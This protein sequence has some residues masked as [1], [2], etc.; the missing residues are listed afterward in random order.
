MSML[1]EMI[2]RHDMALDDA[3]RMLIDRG[4]PVNMF[5]R[6][7]GMDELT[8]QMRQQLEARKQAILDEFD[9]ESARLEA[10]R[11]VKEASQKIQNAA[12]KS[13]EAA[14]IKDMIDRRALDELYRSKMKT[15]VPRAE[16][17]QAVHDLEDLVT[18]ENGQ[19]Q[20]DFRGKTRL[21]KKEALEILELLAELDK[22][23]QALREAEEN[24]DLFNFSL[25]RIARHLGPEQYQ[26]FLE[27]RERILQQMRELME[28]QGQIIQEESGEMRLSPG[29]IRKIGRRALEEIFSSMKSD[30]AGGAHEANEPGDSENTS[31]K[32]RPMEFGDSVSNL[33]LSA[34]IINAF[35][36]RQSTR[37][38]YAEMEVFEPRGQARSSTVMLIDMS[39]SMMRSDRFYNAKKVILALDALI[40]QDYPDEKLLVVGFGTLARLIT[41]AEIPSLQPYP[42][43]M[44]DP[45]IRL[46]FDMARAGMR[47]KVPEYFTNLQRGLEL[48]RSLL[49]SG[50]TRNKQIILITDGVPTAHS[51]NGKLHINYPPSPADF[52]F[53][54]R[55]VRHCTEEEITINTFLLTSDWEM[56]YFGDESFMKQFAK[57]AQGRIF[58]PH[59]TQMNRMVLVDFIH[60]RKAM[61]QY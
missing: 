46:R 61:F 11:D 4:L 20:Y 39:G 29:S 22:L 2:M 33:D 34:S 10:E 16:L 42:V 15:A 21:G 30:S 25:E 41:P 47:E 24:G 56:D 59:P 26:E 7:A 40:R 23:M 14:E 45:H 32:T 36:R 37:P 12:K 51:E 48:A 19:N 8:G 13:P 6:E 57:Q 38:N 3:L 31:S 43:T 55:E 5:L 53:A 17:S 28:K 60:N 58:Y 9:I 44:F 52:E 49:G 54:L 18:I 1:S 50:E 27:R 35:V